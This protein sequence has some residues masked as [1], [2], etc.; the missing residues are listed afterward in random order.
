M[1]LPCYVYLM[2]LGVHAEKWSHGST[3]VCLAHRTGR[4]TLGSPASAHAAKSQGRA[5]VWHLEI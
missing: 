4:T 2:L 3:M 5:I 1:R